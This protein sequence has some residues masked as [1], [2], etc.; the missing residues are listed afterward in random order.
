MEDEEQPYRRE[1]ESKNESSRDGWSKVGLYPMYQP[2]G[3]MPESI[4]SIQ[5]TIARTVF[6]L[7]EKRTKDE[8]NPYPF[9]KPMLCST[10]T[11]IIPQNSR[12]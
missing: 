10:I 1:R 12:S 7:D 5:L 4:Y 11:P 2:T 8:D 3:E 9:T 6:P